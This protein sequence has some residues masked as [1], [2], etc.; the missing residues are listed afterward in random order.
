MVGEVKKISFPS[1][2][3]RT[4]EIGINSC[5]FNKRREKSVLGQNNVQ[6]QKLVDKRSGRNLLQLLTK[7]SSFPSSTDKSNHLFC[8]LNS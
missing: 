7:I 5:L 4:S 2:E 6:V 1:S 8:M 3:S